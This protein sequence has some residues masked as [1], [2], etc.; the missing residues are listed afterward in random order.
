MRKSERGFTLIEIVAAL[1]LVLIVG[2]P[3]ART[4]LDSYKFQSK[5]Q[6]KTEANE[7]A[8]YVAEQLKDGTLTQMEA[9]L[10]LDPETSGITLDT[11]TLGMENL[12]NQYNIE[13][14]VVSMEPGQDIKGSTPDEFSY[15]IV[16][17]EGGVTGSYGFSTNKFSST[18]DV[19]LDG[20]LLTI[21]P[22]E[23][24]G[25]EEK[26]YDFLIHNKTANEVT[27]Q[28]NKRTKSVVNIY[29]KGE[30]AV[31]LKGYPENRLSKEYTAFKKFNL[32]GKNQVTSK[33]EDLYNVV[34]ITT[35]KHDTSITANMNTTF[36]R[37]TEESDDEFTE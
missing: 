28:I 33:T 1:I 37:E 31:N 24:E 34:V 10:K 6:L 27:F 21:A 19:S 29:T 17:D 35:S 16:V 23:E 12:A 11:E 20:F 15:E 14:K 7:V 4:F 2:V 13:I 26:E 36:T 18:G 32:G 3:L 25:D 8:Q 9:A 22:P 30:K 5:S